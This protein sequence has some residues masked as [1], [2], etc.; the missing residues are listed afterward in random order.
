MISSN[1]RF[2]TL[3]SPIF[4]DIPGY[5]IYSLDPLSGIEYKYLARVLVGSG[6]T[7]VESQ[8]YATT[9][10]AKQVNR[11]AITSSMIATKLYRVQK[12]LFSLGVLFSPSAEINNRGSSG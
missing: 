7:Q 1:P 8:K 5:S 2:A 3:G 6:H 12:A 10:L 4:M 9:D 11:I